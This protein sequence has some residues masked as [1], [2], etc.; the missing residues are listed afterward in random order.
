MKLKVKRFDE[1]NVIPFIDVMLVLL[2]IVLTTATF[3]SQGLI[4]V[5]LPES[6]EAESLSQDEKPWIISVNKDKQI[7]LDEHLVTIE[8]LDKKLVDANAKQA[9]ILRMDAEVNFQKFISIMD[10][11]KRYN[12]ENVA[13]QASE[14]VKKEVM[15]PAGSAK[16]SSGT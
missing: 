9:F 13:I 15:V 14:T 16:L 1:M 7:F 3:V 4:P 11:F 2:A 5:E 12:L 6:S 8:S 10:V